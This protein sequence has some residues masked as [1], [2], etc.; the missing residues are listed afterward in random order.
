MRRRGLALVV[1][2]LAMALLAIAAGAIAALG[3]R[4]LWLSRSDSNR[5]Q[6]LLAA[7]AGVAMTSQ[8]LLTNPNFAGISPPQPLRVTRATYSSTV[9][10]GPATAP[11]GAGVPAG[12]LYI[13]ATGRYR[14]QQR[15]IGEMVTLTSTNFKM[16]AFAAEN[17]RMRHDSL[18]ESYDSS[19]GPFPAGRGGR[20]DV[21]TNSSAHQAV[22]LT[23][24]AE[25]KG[26]VYTGPGSSP[27]TVDIGRSARV[28]GRVRELN[29]Q[30][31]LAPVTLPSDPTGLPP[32]ALGAGQHTLEPGTYGDLILTDGAQ[33]R[34][35]AGVPYV[36]N[37]VRMAD[38][39][40]FELGQNVTGQIQVYIAGD[41]DMRGGSVVNK[42][43]RPSMMRFMVK[44]RD[45]V[46]NGRDTD[47]YFVVYAPES[48]VEVA[49]NG[50][51]YGSIVGKRVEVLEGAALRYDRALKNDTGFTTD[52]V[53]VSRQ[54]F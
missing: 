4:S 41:L 7:E 25:I 9:T 23:D 18:T 42:T 29:R 53:T 54:E 52:V 38:D 16:A 1:M 34:L 19:R 2:L 15:Q 17:I 35:K 40:T 45:I 11:N 3:S 39:S 48:K 21:A 43:A 37:S 22:I 46:V 8:Q 13:L 50:Q 5:D 12:M 51:I 36:F 27:R 28:H 47:A 6:A 33:V 31:E 24:N 26:D 32:L 10:A 44:G 20:A 30:R 14:D 49:Q